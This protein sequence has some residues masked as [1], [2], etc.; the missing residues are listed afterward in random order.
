MRES[1]AGRAGEHRASPRRTGPLL[2]VVLL[3]ALPAGSWPRRHDRDL[4]RRSRASGS[5]ARP[6]RRRASRSC[7]RPATAACLLG[8]TWGYDDDG[9]VG[10]GRLRRRVPAGR[11]PRRRPP[12]R[13]H[14]PRRQPTPG[15]AARAR[16]DLGRVRPRQRLPRRQEQ[17]RRAVDQ[18]LRAGALHQ[19]DARRADLHRSPRERAHRRRPQRH[20][21]APG[22]G[23]LQG[24]ARRPEADLHGHLLD[25]ARHE[26]ERHLRQPRLP[27]QPE[28]QPLRRPQREP[29]DALAPGLASLLAR[30]RS[31]DG[32]RV[33]PALLQL[34]R[35][36]PGRARARA[37]GTTRCSA[38][39]TASSASSRAS[40]TASFTTGASMWWMPTT[41]EFGPRG[42]YG[43]WEQHEKVATRFGV[44]TTR[45]PE[46]R[47]T[48]STRRPRQHDAPAGR[49]R[50]RVRHGRAGARRHRETRW[51]TGS[52]RSTPA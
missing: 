41:K 32:R 16:R 2:A 10:G 23:L 48:N 31:R 50:E 40:W 25:R 38:T 42:A 14:R 13:R 36:G 24:V 46:E 45:S 6:T 1:A 8:K 15:E 22:H 37:S 11:R 29:R 20:L 47:F 7:S 39:P 28:V 26:P 43:D 27:V 18:R 12:P 9:R 30:P 49:Q 5:T 44:S 34:R 51:T 19:P 4:R 52:S 3:A 33:L 17:R 35:L 21:A